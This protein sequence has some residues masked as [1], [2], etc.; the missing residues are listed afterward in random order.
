MSKEGRK[1][2]GFST[3]LMSAIMLSSISTMGVTVLGFS[4]TV[5]SSQESR[6]SELYVERS[7]ALQ[8][9]FIMEDV[10]FDE[11]TGI[12]QVHVTIKNVGQLPIK[13][14]SITINGVK[15]STNQLINLDQS[16]TIDRDYGWTTGLHDIVVQTERENTIK[17]SWMP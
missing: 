10:W 11:V 13:V 2:K 7:N 5:V 6:I 8:E 16:A 12:K 15:Y 14:T 3:V 1:N 17:Q 4:N 9:I